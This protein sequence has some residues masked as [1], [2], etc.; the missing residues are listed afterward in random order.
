MTLSIN[1]S[2]TIELQ[3]ELIKIDISGNQND[4]F[5]T[6]IVSKYQ[7]NINR[8]EEKFTALYALK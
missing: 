5:E 4:K 6:K 2:K 8:S 1:S 3:L 7:R